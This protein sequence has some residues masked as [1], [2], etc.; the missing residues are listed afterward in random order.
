[1][2]LIDADKLRLWV[3]VMKIYMFT[4]QHLY[5]ITPALFCQQQQIQ[6]M[7]IQQHEKYKKMKNIFIWKTT[8]ARPRRQSVVNKENLFTFNSFKW[9]VEHLKFENILKILSRKDWLIFKYLRQ[10]K[11]GKTNFPC[12]VKMAVPGS[13]NLVSFS[14]HLSVV[15]RHNF[16][17]SISKGKVLKQQNKTRDFH[18]VPCPIVLKIL[19]LN[20]VDISN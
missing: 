8:K 2:Y 10:R 12:S 9:C 13:V 4:H 5:I 1:M 14:M 16:N 11:K 7:K 17:K 18:K 3:R 19:Y 6:R 15:K 20:K